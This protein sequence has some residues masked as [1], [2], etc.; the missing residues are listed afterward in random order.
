MLCDAGD[1]IS[2]RTVRSFAHEPT[3]RRLANLVA[4]LALLVAMMGAFSAP[5]HADHGD[6]HHGGD[7]E[8]GGDRGH[9]GGRNRD[10]GGK[11]DGGDKEKP[12]RDPTVEITPPSFHPTDTPRPEP[13]NT[14]TPRP[15]PTDEP[16]ST[17]QPAPAS[18]PTAAPQV[19]L[20]SA[21]PCP[22]I[23]PNA[24]QIR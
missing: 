24:Y 13:T 20:P 3:P 9:D 6:H 10:G 21:P 15:A 23:D 4:I 7:R 1:S 17:S 22:M 18:I 5:V 8:R 2:H 11:H 16:T 19:E 14:A 12:P